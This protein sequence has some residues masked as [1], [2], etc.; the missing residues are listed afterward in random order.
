MR[1]DAL[2]RRRRCDRWMRRGLAMAFAADMGSGGRQKRLDA[3][4]ATMPRPWARCPPVAHPGCCASPVA[5]DGLKNPPRRAAGVD[6]TWAT[7]HGSRQR[8]ATP[9]PKPAAPTPR[10]TRANDPKPR[11]CAHGRTANAAQRHRH[12]GAGRRR[13][14]PDDITTGYAV[15]EGHESPVSAHDERSERRAPPARHGDGGQ[16]WVRSGRRAV[17]EACALRRHAACAGEAL[18]AGARSRADR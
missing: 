1:P 3:G 16:V 13:P 6:N 18:R 14:G 4:L 7:L 15:A 2:L 5:G 8:V 12:A 11:P 9:Q 10:A 17:G